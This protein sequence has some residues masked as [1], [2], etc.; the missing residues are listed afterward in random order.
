MAMTSACIGWGSGMIKKRWHIYILLFCLNLGVA[1]QAN[2]SGWVI[3]RDKK[4]DS[5]LLREDKAIAKLTEEDKAYQ[6]IALAHK[7]ATAAYQREIRKHWPSAEISGKTRWVAYS[8]DWTSK[9][10]VDFKQ[11][12]I[13]ISVENKFLN[14]RIDFASLSKIVQSDLEVVLATTVNNALAADPVQKAIDK[15]VQKYAKTIPK[16]DS[17]NGLVL[18]GLFKNKSPTAKDIKKK[19]RMLLKN[20]SIR[21]QVLSASLAALPKKT[22]KKITY[23]IPLH[24]DRMRKKVR[25]YAPIV[26]KNAERFDLST[27][28]VMAI[29]HTESHFNPL[30]RSGVPAF[31]LMQIVPGTAGRDA[32]RKLYKKPHLLSARYLYD[33]TRNIEVGAAYLNVLYYSY[34]RGIKNPESR[35]YY[36]IAAYNAGASNSAKAFINKASLR[37]ALPV[38][39]KMTPAQVLKALTTKLPKLENR[40]YVS[41]VLKRRNFYK[42]V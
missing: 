31:G 38:I 23:S 20:A 3:D 12:H 17:L 11:N 36:T 34:L 30:A 40:E 2:S 9:R 29:I 37:Q 24:G 26:K 5:P 35:L 21:Y 25:E 7:K 42:R 18:A 16:S 13:E 41:K 10:V 28:V 1:S 8:D 22:N 33:P 19:A 32:A 6:A 15:A 39:N 14:S 4:P 27:D